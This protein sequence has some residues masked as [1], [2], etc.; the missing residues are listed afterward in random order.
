MHNTNAELFHSGESGFQ[1]LAVLLG[2]YSL[3]SLIIIFGVNIAT[4]DAL[5]LTADRALVGI[6]LTYDII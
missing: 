3:L 5:V 4:T 2:W 6:I 1:V